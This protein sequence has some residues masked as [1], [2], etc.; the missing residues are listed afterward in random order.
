ML[1]RVVG[2]A[3]GMN[4]DVYD[5]IRC[6][7]SWIDHVGEVDVYEN[8]TEGCCMKR[9]GV[10]DWHDKMIAGRREGIVWKTALDNEKHRSQKKPVV[11]LMKEMPVGKF[12]GLSYG[13]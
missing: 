8:L 2:V 13:G 6:R 5:C 7:S 10:C 3:T 11:Q 9:H 1:H 12:Q 4:G